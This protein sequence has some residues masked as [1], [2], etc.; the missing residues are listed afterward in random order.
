MEFIKRNLFFV[1]LCVVFSGIAISLGGYKIYTILTNEEVFQIKHE[2]PD[3]DQ[4]PVKNKE[5]EFKSFNGE[6]E[7]NGEIS[8]NWSLE[9]ADNNIDRILLYYVDPITNKET[10]LLD[11][12]D[13]SSYRI[14]A[15]IYQI[16][17]G[18]N[19]FKLKAIFTNEKTIE[20]STTVKLPLVLDVT[21][22][23]KD[24][25]PGEA[26][27]VLSFKYGKNNKVKEPRILIYT[28]SILN[29]KV[30]KTDTRQN[31]NYVIVTQEYSFTWDPA[32]KIDPFTIRWYFSD[33]EWNKDFTTDFSMS[34]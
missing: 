34:E 27:L 21:Q 8:F 32:Q 18:E 13:Y 14:N 15:G 5:A 26:T 10:E 30:K 20:T 11:V 16:L 25:K 1:I 24:V 7:K 17:P 3:N 6:Y 29:Y 4:E 33:I 28:D 22:N 12:T 31:G 19:T 9:K 23:V 2:E